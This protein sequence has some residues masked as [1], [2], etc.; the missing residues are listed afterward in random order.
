VQDRGAAGGIPAQTSAMAGDG[1]TQFGGNPYAE[2]R[3]YWLKYRLSFLR[4]VLG[5]LVRG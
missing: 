1:R 2:F 5:A 4:D 3:R